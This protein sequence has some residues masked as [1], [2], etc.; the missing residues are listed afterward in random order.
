MRHVILSNETSAMARIPESF[1]KKHE[2]YEFDLL[3]PEKGTS[4]HNYID[5][6]MVGDA[7]INRTLDA[8]EDRQMAEIIRRL[9][10]EGEQ[11]NAGN[12]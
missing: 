9:Q 3:P 12:Q 5:Q 11:A 4:I 1:W 2:V 6:N 10:V 7:M 8:E